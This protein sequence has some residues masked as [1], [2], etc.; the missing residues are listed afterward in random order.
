MR[1]LNVPSLLGVATVAL[2][3][4]T[5]GCSGDTTASP[6]GGSGATNGGAGGA[7]STLAIHLTDSP[8]SDAS[9]FLITFSEVSVHSADPGAWTT[10]TFSG[11]ATSRTCDLKQLQMGGTDLLGTTPL[12]VGTKYTQIRLTITG[13]ALYNQPWGMGPCASGATLP[14]GGASVDVPSGEVKLNQEFTVTGTGTKIVL[15]FDGD[16]SVHQTGSS[17]GSG[18]YIMNPVIR[19]VSV[20]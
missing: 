8:F 7:M 3:L 10:L 13:A 5:I 1:V 19:V 15:D 20:Q 9:A 11:G 2:S 18:K 16:Q 12:T 4:G 17:K 14:A 6:S